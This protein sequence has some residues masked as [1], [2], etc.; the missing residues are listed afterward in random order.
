MKRSLTATLL[1][2]ATTYGCSTIVLDPIGGSGGGDTTGGTTV[3]GSSSGSSGANA[4]ALNGGDLEP[5]SLTWN[6]AIGAPWSNADNLVLFFSSAPQAC[7]S[8]A[9]PTDCSML[10]YWQTILVIPPE[11][12]HVGVVDLR[13]PAIGVR[14][15]QREPDSCSGTFGNGNGFRGELEIVERTPQAV[16]VKLHDTNVM[17]GSA[18]P[19]DG[20]Y[21]AVRC[22]A[23]AP[24]AP[25]KTAFAVRAKDLPA[26]S[27]ITTSDPDALVVTVTTRAETCATAFLPLGCADAQ[28][29]TV[30]IPPA[31]QG[32]GAA[33]L[34]D[35]AL[36]AQYTI[37]ATQ[38]APS[39]PSASGPLAGGTMD[40]RTLDSFGLSFH[41]SGT[42]TYVSDFPLFEVDGLYAATLCP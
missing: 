40:V 11:L 13:H 27:T 15:V 23:P 28:R 30:V 22:T 41:L 2:L 7:A 42:Y 33:S 39:C 29:L 32:I 38:G 35:P 34:T 6:G 20:E 1:L 37:S 19:A 21:V 36:T 17:G 16:T 3:T 12:D 9:F 24:E 25:P 31:K 5:Q 14:E 26:G 10:G 4:L 18:P 8:P